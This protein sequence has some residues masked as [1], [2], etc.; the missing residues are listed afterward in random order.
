MAQQD[1]NHRATARP[2]PGLYIV[3]TPI[4][5]ARDMTLRALDVLGGAD[6]IACEDTRITARLLAIHGIATSCM[7]YHDHNAARVRPGLIN[8]L[9]QGQIVALVSDAGTPLISDPGYKLVRE[10]TVRG[11]AV[12]P[13]P[14]ASSVLAALMA[15]GLPT[16]RFLFSGFLPAKSAARRTALEEIKRTDATTV[17]FESARRLPATLAEMSEILGDREAVVAR[18]LTKLYEEHRRGGLGELVAHYGGAGAPKGEVVIV[19]G[20]GA[21]SEPGTDELDDMLIKAL[22]SLSVRSA[23]TVIA[24]ITGRPRREI[25]ARAVMLSEDKPTVGGDKGC[26]H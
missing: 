26:D 16:D 3:A 25:Y 13:V 8:R 1:Q 22:K 12:W 7:A 18:E 2:A 21:K 9:E 23:A 20:P 15:A 6:I 4:G 24:D 19:V 10:V 5:N 14:G 11:I 17:I